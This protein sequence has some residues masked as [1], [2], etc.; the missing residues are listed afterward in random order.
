MPGLAAR[1]VV[2]PPPGTGELC[3]GI[4]F[5]VIASL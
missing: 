5:V 1:R 2:V 3:A 4:D